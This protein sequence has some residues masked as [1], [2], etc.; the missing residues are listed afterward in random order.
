M[1]AP[2]LPRGDYRSTCM[3]GSTPLAEV[4]QE[5]RCPLPALLPSAMGQPAST[6]PGKV[7]VLEGGLVVS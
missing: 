1:F 6:D 2:L 3:L 4:L 7:P 5:L